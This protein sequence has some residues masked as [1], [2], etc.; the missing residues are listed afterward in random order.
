MHKPNLQQVQ[1]GT[2]MKTEYALTSNETVN[3]IPIGDFHIGAAQFNY[4]FYE[5]MLRQIKKLKNRRIYLMGD[6]LESAS[7]K[8]GNSSYHTHITLEKQKTKEKTHRH[9]YTDPAAKK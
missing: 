6:L 3:I 2:I 1:G 8:E 5:H 9:N 7:K 4:E